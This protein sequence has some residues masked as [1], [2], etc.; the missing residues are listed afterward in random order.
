LAK[1]KTYTELLA[2]EVIAILKDTIRDIEVLGR[3]YDWLRRHAISDAL[4]KVHD[5][6]QEFDPN[7]VKEREQTA[8]ASRIING[9]VT[10]A[11][12]RLTHEPNRG[13]FEP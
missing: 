10:P 5:L 12:R 7:R 2:E 4:F 3:R 6:V 9:H 11:A 13:L 8:A 1:R